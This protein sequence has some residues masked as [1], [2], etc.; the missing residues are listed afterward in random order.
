IYIYI[1]H[2]KFSNDENSEIITH[3]TLLALCA[4]VG[5]M[6]LGCILG[7]ASPAGVILTSN[8]TDSSIH[9]TDSQ[10]SWFSS[11]S[12]LGALAGCP[13]A[14]FCINYL[15]RRGTII[16]ATI[17]VLIGWILIA[18]AQNFAM[19][20]IGRIITGFYC[21]LISL[22]VPTYVAE[23]SS[24]QIRGALG[25][26]FQLLV[27]VGILFSYCMGVTF[28][29]FR[30]IA[31]SCAV[32]PCICSLL[33]LLCKES[34][35]YLLS[36]GK[37]QEAEAALKS[38][39]GDSYDGIETELRAIRESLEESRR[40]KATFSD[41]KKPYILKPFLMSIGLM[42]FQQFSGINAVLFNLASIFEKAGS[43]LS[44]NVSSIIIG[45]TQIVGTFIGSLLMDRA[46]RKSLLIFSS[47]VM[48]ISLTALGIFFYYLKFSP[49]VAA[50]IG[51]LPLVSLILYVISFAVGFGPIPWLMMGE[52]FSPEVK[53]LA[54]SIATMS[55][56]T[57]AFIT[58]LIYQ[59]L[60]TVIYDYGVYW[61][62]GGFTV[63][64][65]IFCITFVYETKG[66]TLQEINAHFG[67][68]HS[69]TKESQE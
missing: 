55:N 31:I 64:N 68:P 36:K 65:L 32:I 37:D 30:W 69:S 50:D 34:P 22:S 25:S 29:N 7:F 45:L 9:I 21:S 42:F 40:R 20:I 46:G 54:S 43:N 59:P 10:N 44:S 23:F 52:L 35:F 5:A 12:N 57:M 14:G 8:S 56:W 63:F 11:I 48:I 4:T 53:E 19:L 13:L 60:T 17:P 39:R 38:F 61:L 24:P 58:T 2:S 28:T 33:M 3:N 15:G 41:L 26:G 51:W 1:E 66:K 16:Y 27:F 6:G 67:S 47:S 49:S 18:A 62:F